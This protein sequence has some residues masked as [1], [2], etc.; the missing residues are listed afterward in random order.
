MFVALSTFEG[1]HIDRISMDGRQTSRIH[2]IEDKLF[3]SLSL[4][5][6]P[7]LERLFWSDQMG[8][9]ISSTDVEGKIVKHF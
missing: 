7:K 1:A 2:V 9:E 8:G 4:S 3:G 6:D 5:Y